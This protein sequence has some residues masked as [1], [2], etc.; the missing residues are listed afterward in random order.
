MRYSLTFL[1]AVLIFSLGGLSA[2]QTPVKKTPQLLKQGKTL[3]EKYC[4]G[5]HGIQGDGGGQLGR[6]LKPPASDFTKPFAQW[7]FSKGDI[8]RVFS[9]IT[10]GVPKTAMAKFRL[11]DEERWA[12]AYEVVEFSKPSEKSP[13]K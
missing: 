8:K 12:L 7:E 13:S 11:S 2:S 4:A 5:C 9:A 1:A 6:I 3:F 10:N